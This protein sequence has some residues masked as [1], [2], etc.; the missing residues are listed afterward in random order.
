[1]GIAELATIL[2]AAGV[3]IYVLGLIGLGLSIRLAYTDRLARAWYAVSLMPRTVVAGQ[4]MRIWRG[5]WVQVLTTLL[6]PALASVLITVLSLRL[7]SGVSI[8]VKVAAF[9]AVIFIVVIQASQLRTQS[10]PTRPP[11]QFEADVNMPQHPPLGRGTAIS[12]AV[13]GAIIASV[14]SYIATRGVQFDTLTVNWQS[15]TLGVLVFLVGAFFVGV[16][17]AGSV[18]PP[19]PWVVLTPAVESN[20]LDE[21]E[22]KNVPADGKKVPTDGAAEVDDTEAKE[23]HESVMGWLVAHSDGYWHLF[24]RRHVLVSIPDS[25]VTKVQVYDYR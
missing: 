11:P 20:E 4:G 6:I 17:L 19:L 8:L 15:V 1:L 24:D 9:I 12:L 5:S 23:T 25:K 22:P 10:G 16:P 2:T 3:V 21:P 7:H 14:G 18:E 13:T